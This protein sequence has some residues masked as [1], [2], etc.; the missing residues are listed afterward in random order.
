MK[1]TTFCCA[2]EMSCSIY[3]HGARDFIICHRRQMVDFGSDILQLRIWSYNSGTNT[4]VQYTTN[5]RSKSLQFT[6]LFRIFNGPRVA[7]QT[8]LST[9]LSAQPSSCPF[10]HLK[11]SRAS[12]HFPQEVS[13][14][15][16]FHCHVYVLSNSTRKRTAR[17]RNY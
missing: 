1:S 10:G 5:M 11:V 16:I 17:S 9:D 14:P 13:G 15:V 3:K 8:Q 12:H 4:Y 7:L 6:Y 2:L